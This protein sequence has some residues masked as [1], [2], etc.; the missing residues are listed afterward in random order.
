MTPTQIIN[1]ALDHLHVNAAVAIW[2]LQSCWCFH[3]YGL[4][5]TVTWLGGFG[6]C[7]YV[8]LYFRPVDIEVFDALTQKWKQKM[9]TKIVLFMISWFSIACCYQH[10]HRLTSS[11]SPAYSSEQGMCNVGI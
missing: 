6:H 2:K 3:M 11:I 10:C 7:I 1:T 9:E 5:V 4:K 8:L